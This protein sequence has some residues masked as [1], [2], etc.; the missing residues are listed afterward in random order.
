MDNG[1]TCLPP[2]GGR[3]GGGSGSMSRNEFLGVASWIYP[4]TNGLPNTGGGGGGGNGGSNSGAGGS[5]I[6]MVRYA[7]APIGQGG[8]VV[9]YNGYTVH[10]FKG[11]GTFIG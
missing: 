3:T 7:G 2:Q 11:S 5:G 10:V 9:Q 4:A 8:D 1:V 6:V